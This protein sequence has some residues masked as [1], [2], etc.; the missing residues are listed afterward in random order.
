MALPRLLLQPLVENAVYHGIQPRAD[1]GVVALAGRRSADGIELVFSN[2]LP[3][4]APVRRNGVALSNVRARIEYHF[5][6]RGQLRVDP[7]PEVYTVT[8]R[9]PATMLR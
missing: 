1:G 7:G 9:L 8:L 6:A 2:P 5:G 4:D 3:T